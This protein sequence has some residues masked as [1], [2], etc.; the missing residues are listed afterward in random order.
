MEGSGLKKVQGS[1][2]L[3]SPTAPVN[4]ST[5]TEYFHRDIAASNETGK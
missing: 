3:C 5:V 2:R 1:G 4:L